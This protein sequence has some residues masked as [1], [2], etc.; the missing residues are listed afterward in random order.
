MSIYIILALVVV[1][2]FVGW[3]F[4]SSTKKIA[5]PSFTEGKSA[6]SLSNINGMLNN[7]TRKEME[8]AEPKI[9]KDETNN[10]D[11][12]IEE[13]NKNKKINTSSNTRKQEQFN[14][15]SAVIGSSI[16]NRKKN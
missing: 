16:I 2:L 13:E 12:H 1:L 4:L 9:E 15:K 11:E 14:L 3:L 6:H 7:I 8:D 10:I 5:R